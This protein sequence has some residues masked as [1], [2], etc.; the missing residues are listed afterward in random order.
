MA[1]AGIGEPEGVDGALGA[2]TEIL[3]GLLDAVS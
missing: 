2:G 3:N 1:Q